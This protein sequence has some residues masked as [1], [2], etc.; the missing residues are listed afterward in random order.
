M[1]TCSSLLLERVVDV[2]LNARPDDGEGAMLVHVVA[3]DDGLDLGVK[4]IEGHPSEHLL[5]FVAP[6][7]WDALGLVA[8]GWAS[9]IGDVRP[10]QHPERVRTSSAVLVCRDGRVIAKTVTADGA[11]H[12]RPPSSGV[13]LD[14]L[15]RALD[16][17][18]PPPEDTTARLF[19]LHWLCAIAA[20]PERSMR[21]PAAASLHPAAELLMAGGEQ[22]PDPE[23]LI[24]WSGALS[25]VCDWAEARWRSIELGWLE[26]D[27]SPTLA[28]WMDNGM[29]ARWVC[30]PGAVQVAER[31][32]A[33]VLAP[34][35]RREVRRVL[36]KAGALPDARGR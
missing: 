11:T 26:P 7:E 22:S 30:P 9:P 14:C 12:T 13:L 28:A 18:T 21:W 33:A 1:P 5:G 16:L 20:R 3:T 19:A 34:G 36:R 15:R 25:R 35:A 10:S 8:N 31:R 4:P 6:D 2:L 32:A 23:L 24:E 17:D 27:V 29:F